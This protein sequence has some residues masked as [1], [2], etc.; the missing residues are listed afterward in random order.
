MGD[1]TGNFTGE[2]KA[3][4]SH[5]NPPTKRC[6]TW[7]SVKRRIHFHSREL[8]CIKFKPTGFWQ[9]GRIKHTAPVFKAPRAG[10]NAY[11][12]LVEQIQIES[13]RYS[14]LPV[15]KDVRQGEEAVPKI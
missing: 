10:A 12:L 1:L 4:G 14:V 7:H 15:E 13:E 3:C 6:F 8:A 11:F 9:I 2:A 5:F